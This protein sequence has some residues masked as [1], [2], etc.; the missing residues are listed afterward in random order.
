MGKG[1]EL[2]KKAKTLIPGG[3]MLLSK[4]PEM[5]LP[6]Q[7]P[8]YFS[9]AKGCKVWDLDGKEFID[10][11]IMGIGTNILGYGHE[12]V[13]EAVMRTVKE[14]NVSTFNCAEEVELAEKLISLHPWTDMVRY[15]R[16]GGEAVAVAVRI[17]RAYTGKTNIICTGYHG[18]HDW[19]LAN[20]Q[21]PEEFRRYDA[22]VGDNFDAVP[23][24]L[25]ETTIPCR[26]GDIE[27]LQK[28]IDYCM[29][30]GELAAIAALD[31]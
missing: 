15:T 6:E 2:Y 9:K 18:F 29:N 24:Q 26:F 14:G 19:Y 28:A 4:R 11:S 30:N 13:D 31:S 5:F 25:A 7:W 16:G 3:T 10:V 27:S 20:K 22:F 17:A 1:Q 8:A 21:A 23:P 12:E